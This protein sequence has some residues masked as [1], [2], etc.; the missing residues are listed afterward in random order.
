MTKGKILGLIGVICSGLGLF[1]AGLPLNIAALVLGIVGTKEEQTALPIISLIC[2][3]VF[4][5]LMIIY[6]FLQAN[7]LVQ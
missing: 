7:G 6:L 5:T 1:V 4:S 2:G 3:A